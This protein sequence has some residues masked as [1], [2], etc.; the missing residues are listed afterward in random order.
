M[1]YG[2]RTSCAWI[3]NGRRSGSTRAGDG[4]RLLPSPVSAGALFA[5]GEL[6]RGRQILDRPGAGGWSMKHPVP[7]NPPK[8]PVRGAAA[9]AAGPRGS[10]GERAFCVRSLCASPAASRS[11]PRPWQPAVADTVRGASLGAAAATGSPAL[12]PPESFDLAA[13]PEQRGSR[14]MPGL[15]RAC[16]APGLAGV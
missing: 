13:R 12:C 14:C 11:A 3:L 2:E 15:L 1:S 10:A 8:P 7:Y 5:R 6:G 16:C 9:P 4:E